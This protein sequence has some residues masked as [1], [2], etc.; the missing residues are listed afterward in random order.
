MSAKRRQSSTVTAPAERMYSPEESPTPAPV[1]GRPRAKS[2]GAGAPSGGGGSSRG[3]VISLWSG[4]KLASGVAVVIAASLAVAWGAH[5]YAL[6]TPRFAIHQIDVRG[7][8]RLDSTQVARLAGVR[9]GENIFALD[10]ALAEKRLLEDPWV[11]QVK[12]TR[13]LPTTLRVELVEREAGAVASIGGELYLVTRAGEPF[14]ALEPGDPF[15]LPVITGLS[16]ANLARDRAREIER[17]ARALDVLKNYDRVPMSRVHAAEEV[18]LADGGDVTLTVGKAAIVLALGQGP[19][20]KK[21]TMAAEIVG[22]LAA[23]GRTPGIV[24]LDNDARPDR[25]VV[26][27]R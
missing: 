23:K 18:H 6:T 13:Q 14:K 25:V 24:F 3:W 20:H 19:W 4:V 10:T 17:I 11:E 22:R 9:P 15:D 7:G 5:R 26:R 16:A 2:R 21:L 8:R 1:S 12:I 27:M